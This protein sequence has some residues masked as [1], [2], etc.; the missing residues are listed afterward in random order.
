[1]LNYQNN[2]VGNLKIMSNAAKNFDIL[3]NQ[4]ECCILHNYFD[5][6]IYW[7]I[8]NAV[9]LYVRNPLTQFADFSDA[10]K[11]S[12]NNQ[13]Q[14]SRLVSQQLRWDF[15]PP[16]FAER[17]RALRIFQDEAR[18]LGCSFRLGISVTTVDIGL[19]LLSDPHILL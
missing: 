13:I 11:V 5:S 8:N 4:F 3:A 9:F 2:Y 18:L 16:G 17:P 10:T 12:M 7:V 15:V 6:S 1:M 19:R 14:A